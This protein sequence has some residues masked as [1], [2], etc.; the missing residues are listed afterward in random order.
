MIIL[1]GTCA[2]TQRN[3]EQEFPDP[4]EF[5]RP[6][7]PAAPGDDEQQGSDDMVSSNA[8][9]LGYWLVIDNT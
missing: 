2:I 6:G 9:L 5:R 1:V 8:V 4:D 3:Y 7:V